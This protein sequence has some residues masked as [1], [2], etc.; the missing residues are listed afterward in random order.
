MEIPN[1]GTHS[2]EKL[3]DHRLP[4]GSGEIFAEFTTTN[5]YV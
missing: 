1:S 4:L 5:L 3:A 2:F